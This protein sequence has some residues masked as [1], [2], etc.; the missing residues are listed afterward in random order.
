MTGDEETL[1]F[2]ISCL[3]KTFGKLVIQRHNFTNCGIRHM[4]DPITFRITLDQ[5]GYIQALKKIVHPTLKYAALLGDLIRFG[6]TSRG[7]GQQAR[8]PAGM[9]HSR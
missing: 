6:R 4:Q 7:C 3:E 9:G 5:V 8:R 2:I 1:K